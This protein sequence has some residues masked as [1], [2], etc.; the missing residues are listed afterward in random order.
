MDK[1]IISLSSGELRRLIL[2]LAILNQPRILIIDNPFIGLDCQTREMLKAILKT[3]C[4]TQIIQL[5]LVV[6]DHKEIPDFITHVIEVCNMSVMPKQTRVEYV[7]RHNITAAEDASHG[8][9]RRSEIIKLP[10]GSDKKI[11]PTNTQYVCVMS[12][13]HM[14]TILY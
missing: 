6:N 7:S 8:Y 9:D 3:L 13:S 1:R 12:Q 11:F 4:E 5:I 14:V 2:A 10:Y